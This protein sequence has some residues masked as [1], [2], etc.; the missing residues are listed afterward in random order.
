MAKMRLCFHPGCRRKLASD[1]DVTVC[2]DHAADRIAYL[3]SEVR[4]IRA[5]YPKVKMKRTEA[6]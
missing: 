4:A 3:L 1:G 5:A 6:A 2:R